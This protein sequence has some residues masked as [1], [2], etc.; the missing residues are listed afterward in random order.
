MN[1]SV[2]GGWIEGISGESYEA[3]SRTRHEVPSEA[4]AR[5]WLL[6]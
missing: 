5:T 4:R 1:Q 3:R 6:D 2:G